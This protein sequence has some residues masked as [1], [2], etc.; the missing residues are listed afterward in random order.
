MLVSYLKGQ[1]VAVLGLGNSGLAVANALMASGAHVIA[2]DD[3]PKS[4]L[5]AKNIGIKVE[6]FRNIRWSNISSLVVSPGI[7]ITGSKAHWCIKL[8]LKF[9]IEVIGD[10]ELFVR[11]RRFTCVNSHFIA[12][13]G[14]NGKSTT[15]ALIAHILKRNGLDVQLGGNIGKPI[16]NLADLSEDRFYVIECSSYQIDIS[17]TI[18][19]SIGVL[20]SFYPDHLDRHHTVENYARIKQHLVNNSES[21]IICINDIVCEKIASDMV[22]NGYKTTRIYP[23]P[24][25]SAGD[26]YIE[27][28]CIKLSP[29]SEVLLDLSNQNDEYNI[30]NMAAAVTV[31]MQLGLKKEDIKS[32]ISSFRGLPH[33]RQKIAK[34]GNTVF[35]NDSKATNIHSVLNAFLDEKRVIHWIVG[36]LAKSNDISCILAFLSKVTKAYLIGDSA[37]SFAIQLDGKVDYEISETLEKAVISAT[38]YV[39]NSTVPTVVLFSP[40]CASFDQYKNF[41]ERGFSFMSH[42]AKIDGID[43]LVDIEKER[44]SSW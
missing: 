9:N 26:I 32:A 11:E 42:V 18:N 8:A 1:S 39:V 19:P 29:T 40:G 21:A 41:R 25:T 6:D 13:T 10:I 3:N 33:R 20:V 38:S 34:L 12:V 7:A 31:C 28:L 36:G 24:V 17:P 37:D 27:K 14:T 43:M 23:M 44:Q 35:I 16:M 4:V 15:V 22:D 30:H 2:W 5:N